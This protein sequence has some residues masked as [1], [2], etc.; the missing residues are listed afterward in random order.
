MVDVATLNRY[1]ERQQAAAEVSAAAGAR[2]A[3][4]DP[5]AGIDPAVRAAFE[6]FARGER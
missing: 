6:R 3:K 4:E 2:T 5:L 1:V